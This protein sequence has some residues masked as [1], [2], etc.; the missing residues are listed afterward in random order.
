MGETVAYFLNESLSL[1]LERG[2]FY[3]ARRPMQHEYCYY[4]FPFSYSIGL[5]LGVFLS[6]DLTVM[7]DSDGSDQTLLTALL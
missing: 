2:P 6:F 1:K 4:N 3:P 7:R 5:L